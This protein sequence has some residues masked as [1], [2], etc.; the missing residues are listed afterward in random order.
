MFKSIALTPTQVR[1][2]AEPKVPDPKALPAKSEAEFS[3]RNPETRQALVFQG[4]SQF[5]RSNSWAAREMFVAAQLAAATDPSREPDA[6]DMTTRVVWEVVGGICMGLLHAALS[7]GSNHV[8]A[9]LGIASIER[10]SKVS[11]YEFGVINAL[12]FIGAFLLRGEGRLEWESKDNPDSFHPGLILLSSGVAGAAAAIASPLISNWLRPGSV[13]LAVAKKSLEL[14][15][16]ITKLTAGFG[17]GSASAFIGMAYDC[18][19]LSKV[20]HTLLGTLARLGPW[21]MITEL[22]RGPRPE[23]PASDAL[24]SAPDKTGDGSEPGAHGT[25]TTTPSRRSRS[26]EGTGSSRSRDV[27]PGDFSSPLRSR[28]GKTPAKGTPAELGVGDFQTP[29][30]GSAHSKTGPVIVHANTE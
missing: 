8:A 6:A 27:Q 26:G 3:I 18:G 17:V 9:N 1:S 12:T 5:V 25:T 4:L 29:G 11:H 23:Y 28:I 7:N 13:K 10:D 16:A 15:Q 30:K 21:F 24:A 22:A 19:R 14:R 2:T 20:Q